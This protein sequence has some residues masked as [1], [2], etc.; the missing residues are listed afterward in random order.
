MRA[1]LL[2]CLL[3][4][5]L[6][7]F[8]Q[9]VHFA[10]KDRW[11]FQRTEGGPE[12]PAVVP[13][14]VHLDLLR[15][16]LLPDPTIDD[17]IDSVQWV[18][19]V[20]WTYIHR[21]QRAALPRTEHVDLV[22]KGLDT[23]AEVR[24]NGHPVLVADN[25]FVTWERP[26]EHLLVEG[27]NRLE[28]VFSPVATEAEAR[29][30]RYGLQLPHDSDPTG[31][32]P[33]VRKAA[34]QFGWDFVPR[35]VGCGIW[36]E[37]FFRCWDQ[38]RLEDVRVV[39]R[40]QTHQLQ[41]RA[42]TSRFTKGLILRGRVGQGS[43]NE[44]R[45]MGPV[46]GGG[47]FNLVLDL[48][49]TARW[50]P[51]GS[52]ARPM[53]AV[54]LELV[55]ASG[56]VLDRHRT[57]VGVRKVELRQEADSIGRSFTFFVNDRPIF[58]KGANVVPPDAFLSRANDSA[59]VALVAHAAKANMNMLRVWGGGMYPPDAFFAA[60]DTAGI[61]V[62]QDFMFAN[63]PP[64]DPAMEASIRVEAI[65]QVD[66]LQAHPSLALFCGNN[67]LDVAWRNWGWQ[68]RYALHGVDSVRV[69]GDHDHV[70]KVLLARIT[71]MAGISYI[72]TSPL[73]NW[74]NKAGLRSGNMH[75]WG[76]WHAD[77]SFS[78]YAG[79]TGR[80]MAEYGFQSWPDS[81][82]MQRYL[83]GAHLDLRD[84]VLQHRQR[85]YR[86]NKPINE[87]IQRTYGQVPTTYGAYAR[88]SQEVQ[89][90]AMEAAIKAH[91]AARPWCMGTLAWQ[92]NAPWPGPSWSLLEP[93]G[94]WR[95]ALFLVAELF[96]D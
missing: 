69:R 95:P 10:L 36:K 80:F 68:D 84:R 24:L 43:W 49:D 31:L 38:A 76:V 46:D 71:E 33:Y 1:I 85:S 4:V 30:A 15:N 87:A 42:G 12:L 62:W 27:E 93:D 37:V 22:F 86:T 47:S 77:S 21:F 45:L 35:L 92:L 64:G 29:R 34:C 2:A 57:E 96:K 75:Y 59:W 6:D 19:H 78:S 17:N 66:R 63:L 91:L 50:W 88:R 73:S 94:T 56:K 48:I 7:A 11:T 41:V 53:R 67:E 13:G 28:V 82:L 39:T 20:G 65:E 55:T 70:F 51:R 5:G 60:C 25:M 79:N 26:V 9:V 40:P 52:G 18:E 58:M 72:H 16:G 89:A 32:S 44:T 90:D 61:L 8:G 81:A 23:F 83:T 54:E 74:G 3:A 14:E